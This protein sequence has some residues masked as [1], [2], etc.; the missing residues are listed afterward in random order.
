[1]DELFIQRATPIYVEKIQ[2]LQSSAY[3]SEAIIYGDD[4]LPALCESLCDIKRV[5]KT[6][7]ILVAKN[8][9]DD[10]VGAAL[11]RVENNKCFTS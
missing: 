10:I 3:K 6:T 1:M 11:G 2:A 8:S 4:A 9:H 7:L 5:F